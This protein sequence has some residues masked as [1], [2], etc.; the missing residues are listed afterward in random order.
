MNRKFLST[1]LEVKLIIS[2]IFS[3]IISVCIFLLI[4]QIGEN[5]LYNHFNK[6]SFLANKKIET[7][8]EFKNYVSANDLSINDHAKI[9]NWIRKNKYVNIYIYKGSDLVYSSNINDE[10]TSY[11]QYKESPTFPINTL[12]DISF[13]DDDAK[14]HMECFFEYKYYYI[15]AIINISISLLCFIILILFF[16]NKK[17]TYIGLLENEI[18]ILEGGDLTYN[19][20]INS[21]DEL[22]SLAQSIDDMRKSFIEKLESENEARLANSELIT[23]LSHDLRTPLTALVGYLDIIEYKKYKT[24]ENFKQY[25]HNSREKAYQIKYLSDKL[26]EYF[27]V[28]NT[29]DAFDLENFNGNELLEQ[30]IQ[31][32]I[33]MLDN[34]GFFF[35]FSSCNTPFFLE[36]NLI[37]IQR[38]FDNIFSNLSK[39]ADKSKVIKVNYYVEND[40]LVVTVENQINNLK[41]LDSTGIGL[42]TC[43][44]IIEMHNGRFDIKK[45]RNIF[46]ITIT[47]NTYPVLS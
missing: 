7:I 14:M 37:S 2:L 33:F 18:K 10:V 12:V 45:E 38:V 30:L 39:Y 20:T 24:D 16:I 4:Q 1:K 25:I 34:K 13:N 42:K 6:T 32:Q 43:K 3:F 44:K 29:C 26:F 46:G 47:L 23:A 5:L 22:S 40:K 36:V 41:S 17:I 35:S 31:E 9:E 19:I 11:E 28:F 21:N 15:L 8:S 27:T